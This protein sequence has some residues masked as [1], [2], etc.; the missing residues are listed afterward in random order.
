MPMLWIKI[1]PFIFLLQCLPDLT[2]HKIIITNLFHTAINKKITQMRKGAGNLCMRLLFFIVTVKL[3]GF[4]LSF[5]SD[6]H[7]GS[8]Y[9]VLTAHWRSSLGDSINIVVRIMK[10]INDQQNCFYSLTMMKNIFH[11]GDQKYMYLWNVSVSP[12]RI[13][14]YGLLVCSYVLIFVVIGHLF[15]RCSQ[16]SEFDSL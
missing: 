4:C 16:F 5:V 13:L 7:F 1:F 12:W 15:N 11:D 2:N 9:D 6:F 8:D 3:K 14:V 10:Q